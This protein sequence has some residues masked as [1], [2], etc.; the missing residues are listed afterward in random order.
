MHTPLWAAGQ[1]HNQIT[2]MHNFCS[3]TETS[4]LLR[5]LKGF[6]DRKSPSRNLLI[7]KKQ[8]DTLILKGCLNATKKGGNILVKASQINVYNGIDREYLLQYKFC[9][10]L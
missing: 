5:R 1:R 7:A 3:G 10:Q 2:K 9:Q 6:G 8:V 4:N